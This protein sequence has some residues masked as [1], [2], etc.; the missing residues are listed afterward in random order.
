MNRS[1]ISTALSLLALGMGC[2]TVDDRP[3]HA[4]RS[5]PPLTMPK[6]E[7]GIKLLQAKAANG[8]WLIQGRRIGSADDF[9]YLRVD[10]IAGLVQTLDSEHEWISTAS[11]ATRVVGISSFTA[12]TFTR[13]SGRR[14]W[15]EE[16]KTKRVIAEATVQMKWLWHAVTDPGQRWTI[17]LG[18]NSDRL[19][20]PGRLTLPLPETSSYTFA[21]PKTLVLE[22]YTFPDLRPMGPSVS[23]VSAGRAMPDYATHDGF[24]IYLGMATAEGMPGVLVIADRR[25]IWAVGEHLFNKEKP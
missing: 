23:L 1:A 10:F 2:V 4:G 16:F 18:T 12:N 8:A 11:K 13:D 6:S 9:V 19:E 3:D 21:E 25:D 24:V 17:A 20:H 7:G 22:A 14:I 15:V 5:L